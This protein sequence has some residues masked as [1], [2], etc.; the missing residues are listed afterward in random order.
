MQVADSLSICAAVSFGI[1]APLPALTQQPAIG[2]PPP[3]EEIIVTA[4]RRESSLQNVPFRISAIPGE[5][6]ERRNVLHLHELSRQ[7]PGLT[8]VDQGSRAAS[9][10]TGRGLNVAS[11]NE[12]AVLFNTSGNTVATYLGEIPIHVDYRMLD[13][14]RVEILLGP[15]GTLYGAGTLG[16]AIRYMPRQPVLDAWEASITVG[17]FGQDQS[18]DMGSDIRAALN[19]PLV[20]D[21]LALRVLVSNYDD[22]GFTDYPLLLHEPG[23]SNPNPDFDDPDDVEANLFAK[24]DVDSGEIFNARAALRWEITD[25]ISATLNYYLQETGFGG[26]SVNHR[27]SMGIG[28]YEAASRVVE[29]NN[30]E[31]QL[32]S[33]EVAVD[34]GFAELV[35]ATGI[36]RYEEFGQRD[37]TD[38]LLPTGFGFE[39]FPNIVIIAS[40]ATTEDRVNQELRLISSGPGPWSWI[41]GGYYNDLEFDH[42]LNEFAP[43]YA[44]FLG[45]SPPDD[46]LTILLLEKKRRELA[47][48]GEG[49]YDFNERWKITLGARYFEFDTVDG[50]LFELPLFGPGQ[51]QLE[52]FDDEDSG[53]LFK[54]S[55]SYHFDDDLM[56]YLTVS[57]GYRLGGVN[58]GA[59]CPEPS[60]GEFPCLRP[61][62]TVYRPDTTLNYEVGVRN[63]W[64]GGRFALNAAIY[65]IDWEDIQLD[66][67]SEDL[68]FITTNGGDAESRGIELSAQAYFNDR[69]Q[70]TLGYSYNSAELTS[71]SPG[72]VDGE[73]GLP[74]D[75]LAGTP[76]HQ[77]N[78]LLTFS[79][80]LG[81]AW[82]LDLDYSLTYTSDIYTKTGLRSSGEVL[83]G[84]TVQDISA[85]FSSGSNW[86]YRFFVDNLFDEFAETN[87][88]GDPSFIR[89][90]GVH[91]LRFYYRNTLRPRRLGIEVRYDFAMK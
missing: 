71:I 38:L 36:S 64:M 49:A 22:P 47:L 8:V 75:R 52:P 88:R 10:M 15:Q 13:L 32:F 42:E 63:A 39:A 9:R 57:E 17:A 62:E 72:A 5:L 68:F 76:E 80:P 19:A 14:E 78:A 79:R 18:D 55:T 44:E 40:D 69:W 1:F 73:D 90:V 20:N 74:G 61:D 11:L 83:P 66:I 67:V 31:N 26:R 6:L 91:S 77:F 56:T 45:I 3:I 24:M 34:L 37:Q 35:S 58:P 89:D 4:T 25:S 59:R 87:A 28:K 85:T 65:Y 54:V 43:G 46:L 27:H 86:T 53:T 16:G 81:P 29:P 60:S 12:A 30:R 51:G 84:Y 48:F 50:Q 23:V 70:A 41:V 33:L 82:N 2:D 21:K 7:V